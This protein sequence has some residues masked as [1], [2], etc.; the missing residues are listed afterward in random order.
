MSV[1]T[2]TPYV[3]TEVIDTTMKEINANFEVSQQ[4]TAKNTGHSV[5]A[6]DHLQQ[7]SVDNAADEIVSIAAGLTVGFEFTVYKLGA[8]KIT[9][10]AGAA[11]YVEDS[12]AAGTLYCDDVG[13]AHVTLK[14]IATGIWKIKDAS[15]TWTTT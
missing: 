11:E 10:Q 12:S 13:Y 8:G 6:A 7:Y 14:L 15:G 2:V 5:V 3:S 9:I 1:F 4:V